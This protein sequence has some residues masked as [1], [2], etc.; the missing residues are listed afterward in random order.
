[1]ALFVHKIGG[2]V[3]VAVVGVVV[4]LLWNWLLPDIFGFAVINYWQAL[5]LFVLARILLGGFGGSRMLGAHAGFH[6]NPVHEKW[7]K[8]TS[9]ERKEFIRKR[10]GKFHRHHF[11]EGCFWEEDD[12]GS[13]S[14]DTLTKE[15][16]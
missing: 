2:L 15:H 6:K 10:H 1:M 9:E 16:E 8:M 5:G 12:F 14:N 4:M 3:F 7:Q 13:P 11:A